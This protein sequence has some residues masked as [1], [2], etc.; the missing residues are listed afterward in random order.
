MLVLGL[1]Q[2]RPQY[3][4]KNLGQRD[5]AFQGVLDPADGFSAPGQRPAIP[6]LALAQA[7]LSGYSHLERLRNLGAG[8]QAFVF[9]VEG[10]PVYA[11]WYDDGIAQGPD[12]APASI[13]NPT[14]CP[15]PATHRNACPHRARA[16]RPHHRDTVPERW[17]VD[18]DA[19][20]NPNHSP[21]RMGRAFSCR[22]LC[23]VKALRHPRTVYEFDCSTRLKTVGFQL[24]A[25]VAYRSK[26]YTFSVKGASPLPLVVFGTL[27]ILPGQ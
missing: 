24:Q 10:L 5:L 17:S 27:K 3:E 19:F 15:G 26:S 18:P 13:E 7:Q 1:E 12:D 2:D 11:L 20:G 14:T 8:V 4:N 25:K 16:D 23:V 9:T 21:R 22:K 6:S